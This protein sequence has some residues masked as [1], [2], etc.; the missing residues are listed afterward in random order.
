MYVFNYTENNLIKPNV[1]QNNDDTGKETTYLFTRSQQ[2]PSFN[3]TQHSKNTTI[4]LFSALNVKGV[5]SS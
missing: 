5:C 1:E 3:H 2:M 4:K